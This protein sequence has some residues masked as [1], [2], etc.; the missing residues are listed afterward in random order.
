MR[1]RALIAAGRVVHLHAGQYDA[2]GTLDRDIESYAL[3]G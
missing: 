1:S 2:Q 3:G